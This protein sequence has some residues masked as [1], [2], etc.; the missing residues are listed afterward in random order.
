MFGLAAPAAAGGGLFGAAAAPTSAA[1][2]LFGAPPPA[3]SAA[4]PLSFGGGGGLFGQ[5]SAPPP[6]GG[7]LFGFSNPPAT[8]A[9]PSLFGSLYGAAAPVAQQQTV[10]QQQ[11]QQAAAAAAATAAA[12]AAALKTSDGRPLPHGTKW[13]ELSPAAQ[14]YLLDLEKLVTRSREGAS[15]LERDSTLH[16]SRARAVAVAAAA[17][18]VASAAAASSSPSSPGSSRGTGR[19]GTA[20]CSGGSCSDEL[21]ALLARLDA[22]VRAD[23]AAAEAL[24]SDVLRVLRGADAA[25]RGYRSA[26]EWRDDLLRSASAAAAWASGNAGGAGGGGG[27]VNAGNGQNGVRPPLLLAPGAAS[28]ERML[29]VAGGGA[30]PELPSRYLKQ[31]V[32]SLAEDVAVHSG[33]LRELERLLLQ[34]QQPQRGDASGE[35]ALLSSSAPSNDFNR[36]P[37]DAVAGLP[38]AMHAAHG[39][40]LA[41]AARVERLHER[42]SAVKAAHVEAVR[43]RGGG[44]PFAAAAAAAAERAAQPQRQRLLLMQ[45]IQQQQQMAAQQQQQQQAAQQQQQQQQQPSFLALPAPQQPQQQQSFLF[46]QQPQQQQQAPQQQQ[47]Q[48]LFGGG[49]FGANLPPA[50]AAAPSLFGA[51]AAAAAPSLF[52]APVRL[53]RSLGGNEN[54]IVKREKKNDQRRKSKSPSLST[55]GRGRRKKKKKKRGSRSHS[56]CFF[57]QTG[58]EPARSP[59]LYG[60]HCLCLGPDCSL[61]IPMPEIDKDDGERATETAAETVDANASLRTSSPSTGGDDDRTLSCPSAPTVLLRIRGLPYGANEHDVEKFFCSNSLVAAYICRR[62]GWSY[63][64]IFF[65]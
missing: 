34:V 56:Y 8:S 45:Q 31:T 14:Q 61:L 57:D 44:D 19:S 32:A 11:Q 20:S 47:Q 12:A 9:A 18:A 54:E 52:G 5:T 21:A 58:N 1:P 40:L 59:S 7:G 23:S 65:S 51:P 24:R 49:L 26:M 55:L 2:S 27:G 35:Q 37:T 50:S 46:Q 63:L 13:E 60:G 64:S 6:A 33:F 4:P 62:A 16:D 38:A 28:R 15:A 22:R 3:A 29:L 41:V 39:A 25:V 53:L 17:A 30:G 36:F 43:R 48:S 42:V 10:Q